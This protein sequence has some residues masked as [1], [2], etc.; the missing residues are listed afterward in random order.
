MHYL[1]VLEGR[2]KY[3]TINFDSSVVFNLYNKNT[4]KKNES[5]DSDEL[6][7]FLKSDIDVVITVNLNA[8]KISLST[9]LS[10]PILLFDN[11]G[12]SREIISE[13]EISITEDIV[14]FK[15]QN[16]DFSFLINSIIDPEKSKNSALSSKTKTASGLG[17]V[18]AALINFFEFN[19]VLASVILVIF[20]V[21]FITGILL[22]GK[23][24]ENLYQAAGTTLVFNNDTDLMRANLQDFSANKILVKT[25]LIEQVR[26]YFEQQGYQYVKFEL[27]N[28]GKDK[29]NLLMSVFYGEDQP[30]DSIANHFDWISSV[31]VQVID[32]RQMIVDFNRIAGKYGLQQLSDTKM[33]LPSRLVEVSFVN[34]N[35]KF[36][37][38]QRDLHAFYE[39]W[40]RN[41]IEFNV[42]LKKHRELPI[43]F[44]LKDGIEDVIKSDQG[45][46][47]N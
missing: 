27:E 40:G 10:E 35:L 6:V 46:Y 2:L 37:S 33:V 24:E 44:I 7:Y 29:F 11:T 42:S 36:L 15:I 22:V 43:D 34:N 8:Y 41:Y 1:Y 26:V 28:Q 38:L 12:I 17:K 30:F 18:K 23:D 3:E 21:I 31:I 32:V 25:H 16:I 14:K 9:P 20:L 45:F 13:Q 47:I 19:K 39:R 4:D 5:P